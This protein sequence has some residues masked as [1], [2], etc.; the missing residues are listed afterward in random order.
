VSESDAYGVI[1]VIRLFV[2]GNACVM[3]LISLRTLINLIR[4]INPSV[5]WTW[6]VFGGELALDPLLLVLMRNPTLSFGL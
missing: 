6:S 4:L 2:D 1:K 5:L 3:T